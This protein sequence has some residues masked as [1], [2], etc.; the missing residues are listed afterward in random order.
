[1]TTRLELFKTKQDKMNKQDLVNFEKEI[2]DIYEKGE[3]KGP[4][5]LRDGNEDFLIDY[6]Y[7]NVGKRDYVFTTWA[8]HL[9]ALLKGIPKK[10]VKARILEGESM[11]MNFPEYN[12]YTSAIVGG[13]L[14]ISLGVS[15]VVK[16]SNREPKFRQ[17]V[18]CF[19]GDMT[20]MTGIASESIRYAIGHDLPISFIVQDNGKSVGTDTENTWKLNVQYVVS[21][22]HGLIAR[23]KRDQGESYKCNVQLHYHKYKLNYPH[24]GVGKFIS[25]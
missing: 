20:L 21:S 16:L 13:I 18:H 10:K 1:M 12:F 5:H 24:S 19:I 2:A 3:I 14:P 9:E 23:A 7:N 25:F 8:N 17:R 6:F 15:H 11:A 4:I 22:F